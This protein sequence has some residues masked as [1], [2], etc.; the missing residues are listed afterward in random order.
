MR[1]EFFVGKRLVAQL[2]AGVG[3]VRDEFA[4]KDVALRIDG[5]RHQLEQPRDV[6]L[7]TEIGGGLRIGGG[8]R[9]GDGCGVVGHVL[10]DEKKKRMH[11]AVDATAALE[12][13]IVAE[14]ARASAAGRRRGAAQGG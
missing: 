7:K 8:S 14:F 5:V 2:F 13:V 10:S 11:V 4:Q 3:G 1:G 6:G 9:G 12:F